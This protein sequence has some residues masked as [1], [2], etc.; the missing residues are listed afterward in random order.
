MNVPCFEYIS[1]QSH[2]IESLDH[3]LSKLQLSQR[4]VV[5]VLE[6]LDELQHDVIKKIE[7]YDKTKP[8]PTLPY[9]LYIVSDIK[10]YQGSLNIV[11]SKNQLPALYNKKEKS[12]NTKERNY[13]NKIKLK[14][15]NFKSL[16]EKEYMNSI[17]KYAL[18]HR[19]ISEKQ[20]F[21]AYLETINKGLQEFYGKKK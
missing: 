20:N 1:V 17:K 13:L 19:L 16:V 2:Q 4:P 8:L 9:S 18:G 7:N 14:Q 11:S 12:L 6:H 15:E 10:N 21:L 3:L 5:L